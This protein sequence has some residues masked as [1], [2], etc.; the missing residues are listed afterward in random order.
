M[1]RRFRYAQGSPNMANL[2]LIDDDPDL[3]PDQIAHVFPSPDHRVEVAPT[4]AEGLSRAA[5]VQPDVIVRD[6]RLPD[7]SGLDVLKQLRQIVARIP[8]VLVTVIR[9]S[10]PAIEADE[11]NL[12]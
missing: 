3:L 7:Q 2:L 4:G 6:L 5:A 1:T 9:S 10:D 8:V 11:D 12:P